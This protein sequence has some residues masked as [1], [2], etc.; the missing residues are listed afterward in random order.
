MTDR[1]TFGDCIGVTFA[2][3]DTKCKLKI[4]NI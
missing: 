1:R 3:E 2:S 4:K